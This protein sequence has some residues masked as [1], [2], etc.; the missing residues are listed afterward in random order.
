MFIPLLAVADSFRFQWDPPLTGSPIGYNI[1]NF[2]DPTPI[3]T[4]TLTEATIELEPGSYQLFVRAFDD[5]EEGPASNQVQ[6]TVESPHTPLSAPL[7]FRQADSSPPPAPP[8]NNGGTVTASS[9]TRA[10]V[11]AALSAA[12]PG[13]RVV[14]PNGAF[15]WESGLTV[16]KQVFFVG[17]TYPTVEGGALTADGFGVSITHNAGD[18]PLFD[19]T[20][21]D[22]HHVGL[23]GIAFKPGSGRGAYVRVSGEGSRPG[24]IANCHL[25]CNQLRYGNAHI[26]PYVIWWAK[27]GLIF[28]TTWEARGVRKSGGQN[29]GHD[30]GSLL[31]ATQAPWQSDDTMGIRD[32]DGLT[33]VYMEDCRAYGMG[34]FPDVDKGGRAV[35]RH[36]YL[37]GGSGTVHG[38]TSGK[39]NGGRHL[40]VYNCELTITPDPVGTGEEYSIHSRYFWQR[41]GHGVYHSNV[42]T[43]YQPWTSRWEAAPC[44]VVLEWSNLSSDTSYPAPS[45][46]GWGWLNGQHTRYGIWSWNNSGRS[47]SN[48]NAL[49]IGGT[50]ANRTPPGGQSS[51]I[52]AG[53]DVFSGQPMTEANGA[54]FNYAPF[55]YPHPLRAQTL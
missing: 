20:T 8:T 2:D 39:F 10:A 27:G 11:A 18:A 50:D 16:D 28:N 37:D 33:N 22:N 54:P 38:L 1:Y 23:I 41:A 42:V 30:G 35:I 26:N 24:I 31:I 36:C 12:S 3:T 9:G 32:I 55:P 17:Q 48:P 43:G 45:Q 7:N 6:L 34:Q 21:D 49:G 19:F 4:A 13:D 15:Q 53:R 46:P 52:R 29:V 25:N 40:E 5:Q 14:I 47:H 51:W 44:E